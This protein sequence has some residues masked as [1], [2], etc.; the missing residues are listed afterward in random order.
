MYSFPGE[1]LHSS[2]C[3]EL[4]LCK[5]KEGPKCSHAKGRGQRLLA[6]LNL[7][8][9]AL[10]NAATSDFRGVWLGHSWEESGWRITNEKRVKS[11]PVLPKSSCTLPSHVLM[12]W[13]V[14][15]FRITRVPKT[16]FPSALLL[17]QCACSP[18]RERDQHPIGEM[19]TEFHVPSI[20]AE[21]VFNPLKKINSSFCLFLGQISGRL[22]NQLVP[23]KTARAW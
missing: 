22:T 19:G 2:R 12:A 15:N 8:H 11:C 16:A 9:A 3:A 1:V 17:W 21:I 6:P 13:H 20:W 14:N 10:L 5:N 18:E 23:W 7:L 4:N